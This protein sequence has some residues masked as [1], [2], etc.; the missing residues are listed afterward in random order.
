MTS[1]SMPGF[2]TRCTARAKSG[3]ANWLRMIITASGR[4]PHG[5]QVTPQAR[6][7][8]A[9]RSSGVLTTIVKRSHGSVT[10]CSSYTHPTVSVAPV[11]MT[12][13]LHIDQ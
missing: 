7:A 6:R 13:P 8:F 5:I 9:G 1:R 4:N 3:D 10:T 12:D 11:G 2:L